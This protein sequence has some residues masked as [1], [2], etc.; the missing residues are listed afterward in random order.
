MPFHPVTESFE[1]R[2]AAKFFA[3]ADGVFGRL[4]VDSCD[5][6]ALV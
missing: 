4:I 3:L 2:I 1:D 5:E 6:F